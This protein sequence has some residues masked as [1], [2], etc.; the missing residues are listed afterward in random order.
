MDSSDYYSI[1]AIIADSQVCPTV[2]TLR[3]KYPH[4]CAHPTSSQ[5]LPCTFALDV[6]GLGYLDGGSEPDVSTLMS[7]MLDCR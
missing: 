4:A 3:E 7:S 5:K 1:E 6:P 2:A